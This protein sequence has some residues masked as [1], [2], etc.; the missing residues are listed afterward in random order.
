MKARKLKI[1]SF[2][3]TIIG[4]VNETFDISDKG[5]RSSV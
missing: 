1:S 3:N 5:V 4:K 2:K